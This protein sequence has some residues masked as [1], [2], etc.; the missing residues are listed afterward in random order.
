ML[1]EKFF[2]VFKIISFVKKFEVHQKNKSS[3]RKFNKYDNIIYYIIALFCNFGVC[4][5]LLTLLLVLWR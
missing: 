4:F 3:L 2:E 1:P 5:V